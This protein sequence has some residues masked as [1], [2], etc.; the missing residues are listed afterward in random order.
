MSL[1][2]KAVFD[3]HFSRVKFDQKLAKAVYQYQIGYI[4]KNHEHLEFF[5]SALLGVH[6]VRF[7]DKDVLEMYDEILDID[8]NDLKRD[9]REVKTINHDFKVS[10][11][12]FNLTMMYMMHRFLTSELLDPTMQ[13]RGAYDVALVFFY[14]CISALMSDRF[15][16][17]ADPKV[18]QA[19]YSQL[20]NKHLIKQLGSWHRVMEYRAEN[21]TGSSS[22]HLK[23]LKKFD[24]DGAIVY[25]INDSQGR[26]RDMFKN[27]YGEFVKANNE[28]A[29]ISVTSGTYVDAEGEETI[30][31][32]TKSA[33]AYVTYIRHALMDKHTFI[34]DDLI[35]IIVSINSNSS[36]RTIRHTLGWMCEHVNDGKY[37]KD[38]DA[39]VTTVVIQSLHL[40]KNNMDSKHM[41]DYPYIL[42]QLKNLYLSTR[43]SDADIEKI[44]DLG[45]KLMVA[46]NGKVSEGLLL[47]T[48][49][50]VILYVSL[51][52]LVGQSNKH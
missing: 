28:G 14:R 43:T 6:V 20:S 29:S 47:A 31:E 45:Y 8:F 21:L 26:I 7:K 27:Y 41:R 42:T 30:K 4:N 35:N 38:I 34:K 11:D 25:A 10:G 3:E 46:A 39:F 23:T 22:I 33:E 9:I 40:I 12:I 36:Y 50:S 18:A 51:R 15:R 48:R 5:G 1:T 52:A 44:R 17:P 13:L 37:Q 19:A 32:K 16:Y 2:L 49:T 24:D